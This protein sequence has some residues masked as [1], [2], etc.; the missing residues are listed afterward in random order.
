MMPINKTLFVIILVCVTISVNANSDDFNIV[1]D[2]VVAELIKSPVDDYQVR[3]IVDKMNKDG[4]FHD[5]NYV[6]LSRAAGFPQRNH[7]YN[8]V[9]LAKA[10]KNKTSKFYQSKKLKDIITVGYEYWV[11]NDFFGDNWHNNQI[12]TP[13]FAYSSSD[14]RTTT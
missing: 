6:D 13:T 1:K 12:S 8:L 14:H 3:T 5:I 11:N 4:S 2:M 9:Y 7:T 10:Y